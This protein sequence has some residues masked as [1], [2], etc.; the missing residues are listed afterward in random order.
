MT[1]AP[2]S[3][4]ELPRSITGYCGSL[5]V[6]TGLRMSMTRMSMSIESVPGG[7]K[8][9]ATATV[10]VWFPSDV[11][12]HVR[13]LPA[14]IDAGGVGCTVMLYSRVCSGRSSSVALSGRL[15]IFSRGI[16][17]VLVIVPN[18]GFWL[19]SVMLT[20]TVLITLLT[21]SDTV[22]SNSYDVSGTSAGTVHSSAALVLLPGASFTVRPDGASLS[23][24]NVKPLL[25]IVLSV[26][27]MSSDR[28]APSSIV[29]M[30]SLSISG[31]RFFIIVT[32]TV[33]VAV[34][35]AE[36]VTT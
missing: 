7:S 16:I 25:E 23:S 8:S 17:C 5:S 11:G 29:K 22:S 30:R 20:I 27:V 31:A 10:I 32:V 4:Y 15:S 2:G 3:L 26:I 9:S 6:I 24:E 34:R 14:P 12:F 35:P 18:S 19:T 33:A 13:I 36:S 28:V 21:P 1:V